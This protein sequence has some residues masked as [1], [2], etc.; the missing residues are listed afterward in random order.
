M[1]KIAIAV[2]LIIIGGVIG[3]LYTQIWNPSWNPFQPIPEIV[4]ARMALK[5]KGVK[6]FHVDGNIET[7]NIKRTSYKYEDE[8]NISFNKNKDSL[9]ISLDIDKNNSESQDSH[10]IVETDSHNES[11]YGER[12]HSR[13]SSNRVEFKKIGDILYFIVID[14]LEEKKVGVEDVIDSRWIKLNQEDLGDLVDLFWFNDMI[15]VEISKERQEELIKELIELL[16]RKGL[17]EVKEELPSEE[18]NGQMTYHYL[19]ALNERETKHLVSD[20]ILKIAEFVSESVSISKSAQNQ[21]HFDPGEILELSM[22]FAQVNMGLQSEIGRFFEEMEGVDIE[23]WIGQ[24]D[25]YLH[26]IRFKKERD[27]VDYFEK[28]RP[29]WSR[30]EILEAEKSILVDIN[31]SKFEELVE[32]NPPEEFENL[33]EILSGV[34]E[35]RGKDMR[36]SR[37]QSDIRQISLAME[38]YYDDNSC[39]PAMTVTNNVLTKDSYTSGYL[40]WPKDPGGGVHNC[41]N[42]DGNDNYC[43]INNSTDQSMYCVFAALEDGS[44][45]V[46]S[47]KGTKTLDRAP[48]NLSECKSVF[49]VNVAPDCKIYC[50]DPDSWTSPRGRICICDPM[51]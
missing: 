29:E 23:V 45:F 44:Y 50:S 15:D 42:G 8:E 31:L 30:E 20:A 34:I 13:D 9:K 22:T 3:A 39:Y 36:D 21:G 24:R 38:M 7:E 46:A 5:M 6:T 2:I 41:N 33:E 49:P 28:Q 4:L 32:I 40:D 43:A 1:R 17:C 10:A 11:S 14:N 25:N 35:E 47:E 26:K 18:I 27:L 19:L 16:I 12:D 48:I 51:N 37:R